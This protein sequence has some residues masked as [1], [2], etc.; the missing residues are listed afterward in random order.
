MREP[1]SPA[2]YEWGYHGTGP[3]QLAADVLHHFGVTVED[4]KLLAIDFSRDVVATL[5]HE[6]DWISQSEVSAWLRRK[7]KTI[8]RK[9]KNDDQAS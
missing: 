2:S 9:Y 5:S 7:G 3:T 1:F 6:G 8:L 4:A